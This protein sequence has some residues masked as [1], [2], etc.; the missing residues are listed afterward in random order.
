MGLETPGTAVI[1]PLIEIP[2]GWLKLVTL[3]SLKKL[4]IL[5][6]QSRSP[7]PKSREEATG[8][9]VITFLE[10]VIW[11]RDEEIP[12]TGLAAPVTAGVTP[13]IELPVGWLKLVALASLK[14]LCILETQRRSLQPKGRNEV[15]GGFG[16]TVFETVIWERDEEI[17]DI[18]PPP[19][20]GR[21]RG[22]GQ[23]VDGPFVEVL[24]IVC[25]PEMVTLIG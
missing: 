21:G 18:I 14:K 10:S 9:A 5:E 16:K 13:L 3:A 22:S 4:C 11:E 20:E 6:T 23:T 24:K 19:D 25:E 8:E 17:P 7:Q 2:V 15:T 12:E 1:V